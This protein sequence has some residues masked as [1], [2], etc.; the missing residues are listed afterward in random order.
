MAEFDFLSSGVETDTSVSVASTGSAE[1]SSM[2][3]QP[4]LQAIIASLLDALQ[5]R[6]PEPQAMT[7]SLTDALLRIVAQHPEL[8]EMVTRR[9]GGPH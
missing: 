1:P 7:A 9:L 4:A 8:A 5:S 6:A 3:A 2:E